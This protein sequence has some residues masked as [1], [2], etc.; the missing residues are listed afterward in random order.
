MSRKES[1]QPQEEKFDIIP[2]GWKPERLNSE[3]KKEPAKRAALEEVNTINTR[4]NQHRITKYFRSKDAIDFDKE[5]QELEK[6]NLQERKRRKEL[7]WLDKRKEQDH[8]TATDCAANTMDMILTEAWT[9]IVQLEEKRKLK[10]LETAGWKTL[11]A[12]IRNWALSDQEDGKEP[13]RKR[14][15]DHSHADSPSKKKKESNQQGGLKTLQSGEKH[16]YNNVCLKM[17]STTPTTIASSPSPTSPRETTCPATQAE[18]RA[19]SKI[20]QLE[21][22]TL[23]EKT[24]SGPKTKTPQVKTKRWVK[25]KNGLFGWVTSIV[26]S[27]PSAPREVPPNDILAGGG[28]SKIYPKNTENIQMRGG[29][30]EGLPDAAG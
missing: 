24:A 19:R 28:G 10:R 13:R 23:R 15:K 22:T 9:I 17:P 2:D 6:E 30:L 7:Q 29:G 12:R 8:R 4:F 18:G 16:V 5:I 25:K 14:R 21:K 20:N 3:K 26:R 27:K 1:G 11:T